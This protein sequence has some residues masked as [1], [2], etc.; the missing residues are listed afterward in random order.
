MPLDPN[1]LQSPGH[2]SPVTMPLPNAMKVRFG[3]MATQMEAA[4][5]QGHVEANFA[6][7]LLDL[8]K[9]VLAMVPGLK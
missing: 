9:D 8:A 7:K 4:R 1:D 5:I 3:D 6:I 2:P